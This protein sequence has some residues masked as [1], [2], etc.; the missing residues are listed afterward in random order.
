MFFEGCRGCPGSSR[1]ASRPASTSTEAGGS[2]QFR[3]PRLSV[4]LR[5]RGRPPR[6]WKNLGRWSRSYAPSIAA[7]SCGGEPVSDTAYLHCRSEST[8]ETRR[9]VEL[10][11]ELIFRQT[12]EGVVPLRE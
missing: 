8:P 9:A 5:Q 10:A 2:V 1:I 3:V 12:V 6:G 7:F 4:A 11:S